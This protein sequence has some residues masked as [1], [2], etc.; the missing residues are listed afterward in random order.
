MTGSICFLEL[1]RILCITGIMTS[2]ITPS[3]FNSFTCVAHGSNHLAVTWSN[4]GCIGF[5]CFWSC[6][7]DS[8]RVH[9]STVFS[10]PSS[11]TLTVS[12]LTKLK[13]L[14]LCFHT[15]SITMQSAIFNAGRNTINRPRPVPPVY[16]LVQKM[17]DLWNMQARRHKPHL[18]N[19]PADCRRIPRHH[20]CPWGGSPKFVISSAYRAYSIR[21]ILKWHYTGSSKRR[22]LFHE[23]CF[24]NLSCCRTCVLAH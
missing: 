20:D 21:C 2:W 15:P 12:F 18:S 5:Y 10:F 7:Q 24:A 11:P 22:V 9:G 19:T 17:Y 8:C 6:W 23:L 4:A 1:T 16:G 13:V 14:P 3:L